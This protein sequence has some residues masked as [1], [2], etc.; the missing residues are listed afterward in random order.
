[1]RTHFP[2]DIDIKINRLQSGHTLLPSHAYKLRLTNTDLC[3]CGKDTGTINHV[4]LHCPNYSAARNSHL[5]DLEIEGVYRNSQ[6]PYHK[7]TL[8]IYTM[9]GQNHTL[10]LDVW[11]NILRST[12]RFIAGS[13]AKI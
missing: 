2:R 7:R 3:N 9:L 5:G 10:Q 12:A 6:T 8:D 1:M 4:M 13:K 11:L